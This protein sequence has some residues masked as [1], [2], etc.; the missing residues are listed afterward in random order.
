MTNSV[1][2]N[3]RCQTLMVDDPSKRKSAL[4]EEITTAIAYVSKVSELIVL[5]IVPLKAHE[6][7]LKYLN[8]VS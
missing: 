1:Q 6:S 3:K 5:G 2:K 4:W 8:W 7:N